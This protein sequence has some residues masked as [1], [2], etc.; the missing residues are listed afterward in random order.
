MAAGLTKVAMMTFEIF[1]K[2]GPCCRKYLVSADTYKY[3][4]TKSYESFGFEYCKGKGMGL[5]MWH[6]ADLY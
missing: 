2:P 4:T 5:A 3:K 1:V 6:T